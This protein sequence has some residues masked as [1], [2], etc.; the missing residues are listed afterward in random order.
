MD[1][2]KEQRCRIALEASDGEPLACTASGPSFVK[3]QW[4]YNELV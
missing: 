2:T 3:D 1:V 4:V